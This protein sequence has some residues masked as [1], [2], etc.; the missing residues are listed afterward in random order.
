MLS[1]VIDCLIISRPQQRR[2]GFSPWEALNNR[3]DATNAE[4]ISRYY[5]FSLGNANAICVTSHLYC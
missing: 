3:V 1:L 5:N 2:R 4:S